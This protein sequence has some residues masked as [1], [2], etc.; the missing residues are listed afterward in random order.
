MNSLNDIPNIR[1]R[2]TR[3]ADP[4]AGEK[5]AGRPRPLHPEGQTRLR[6]P[7]A[8]GGLRPAAERVGRARR[9]DHPAK[10]G[11]LGPG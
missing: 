7:G 4:P 9:R 1:Q 10:G 6:D 5:A 8:F 11:A 3:L 2:G